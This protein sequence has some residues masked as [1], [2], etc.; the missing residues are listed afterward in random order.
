MQNDQKVAIS[1]Y[2]SSQK[3]FS[4]HEISDIPIKVPEG[5]KLYLRPYN[6]DSYLLRVQ[7][8]KLAKATMKFP[9]EW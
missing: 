7:N 9:D 4:K 2:E 8:F 6:D 3:T 5:V 1:F